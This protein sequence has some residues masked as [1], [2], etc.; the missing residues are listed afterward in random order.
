MKEHLGKII[1]MGLGILIGKF[2]GAIVGLFVGFIIDQMAAKGIFSRGGGGRKVKV[3]PDDTTDFILSALILSAAVVKADGEVSE[4]ELSYIHTFL[5]EQFGT[6]K[7]EHYMEVLQQSVSQDF[8]LPK[9]T[10]EIRQNN[11]Y[12]TRLQILYV[13]FGIAHADFSISPKEFAVLKNISVHLSLTP[14]DYNSIQAMFHTE[15]DGYYKILEVIPSCSDKE[16]HNAY[17]EVAKK[18]HP[19]KVAHLGENVQKLAHLKYIKVTEAYDAIKKKR[20]MG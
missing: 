11:T 13:L 15:L 5:A 14:D 17:I 16:L 7:V 2:W 4:L 8:D 12:E 18:Y 10:R 19:D 6:E 1:G 3:E 20:G 9:V